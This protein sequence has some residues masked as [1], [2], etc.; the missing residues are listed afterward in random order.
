MT[1]R[2]E[3]VAALTKH[4]YP[5]YDSRDYDLTLVGLRKQPGTPNTFDDELCVLYHEN[6]QPMFKCYPFTTDPG[7]YWLQ[8]PMNV[9]GTSIMCPGHYPHCWMIGIHL[10]GSPNAYEALVQSGPGVFDVW[11][12]RSA[13]GAE[14]YEGPVY[15]D[16]SGVNCHHAGAHSTSVD[17][18]SAGCQ[19]FANYEDFTDFMSLAYKQR[20]AGIGDHFSYTLLDWP[21]H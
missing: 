16:A 3:V 5:L 11:R 9:E 15:K 17:A 20:A 4:G 1:T 14:V 12:E 2:E 6:G 21:A 10:Y 7:L 8:H 13:V 19:V 18:W